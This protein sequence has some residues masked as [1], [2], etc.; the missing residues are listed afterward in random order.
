MALIHLKQP[1][2][3]GE[4]I[5]PC[6]QKPKQ[7][8]TGQAG[9]RWIMGAQ[10]QAEAETVMLKCPPWLLMEKNA[11]MLRPPQNQSAVAPKPSPAFTVIHPLGEWGLSPGRCI[12]VIS[13]TPECLRGQGKVAQGVH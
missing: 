3:D 13:H 2:M 9:V 4:A 8:P 7:A 1:A 6:G 5:Q 10:P 11:P 12:D